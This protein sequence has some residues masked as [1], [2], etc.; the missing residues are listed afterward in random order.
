MP[1]ANKLGFLFGMPTT[2]ISQKPSWKSGACSGGTVSWL[3][4]PFV[5]LRGTV[6]TSGF[7]KSGPWMLMLDTTSFL[8][9]VPSG[10]CLN[11]CFLSRMCISISVWKKMW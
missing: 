9:Y 2:W 7:A 11:D 10:S 8:S 4:L 5:S 1:N 3:L 6:K